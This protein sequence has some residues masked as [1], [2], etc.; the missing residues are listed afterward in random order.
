MFCVSS[1]TWRNTFLCIVHTECRDLE[2]IQSGFDNQRL[3]LH[4]CLRWPCHKHYRYVQHTNNGARF[5]N[6]YH[7]PKAQAT[8]H[9]IYKQNH[10]G[11]VLSLLADVLFYF[12]MHIIISYFISFAIQINWLHRIHAVFISVSLG[13]KCASNEKNFPPMDLHMMDRDCLSCNVVSS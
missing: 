7:W 6:G 12:N 4:C 3:H 8:T 10:W 1:N 11:C 2:C 13:I 9:A 5:S